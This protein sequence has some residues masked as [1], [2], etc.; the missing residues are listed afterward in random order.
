MLSV[1]WRRRHHLRGR[2]SP[3]WATILG[4][5]P[6]NQTSN[7][8]ITLVLFAL[9]LGINIISVAL[10][11]RINNVAVFTEI[12][13]TVG[14]ALILIMLFATKPIHPVSFLFDTGGDIITQLPFAALM[15]I[16]TIVGFELAG[17][18]SSRSSP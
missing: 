13:G 9:P 10:A 1:G 5:D 18:W 12:V 15:G 6:T 7:L 4:L 14:V 16:F 3:L 17:L 8:I 2:G 11:A